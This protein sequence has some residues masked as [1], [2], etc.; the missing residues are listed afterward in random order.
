[1]DVLC[2]ILDCAVADDAGQPLR[3]QSQQ[4]ALLVYAQVNRM[5]C[6]AAQG[7][8]FRH[9]FLQIRPTLVSFLR[10]ITPQTSRG[11]LLS[12]FVRSVTVKLCRL[13]EASM[14]N[15]IGF[16]HPRHLSTL[17]AHLPSLHTLNIRMGEERVDESGL[18]GLEWSDVLP[19]DKMTSSRPFDQL[20]IPTEHNPW[21]HIQS[22]SLFYDYLLPTRILPMRFHTSFIL[23]RPF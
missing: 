19:Y 16:I 10:S 9:V 8:L 7:I 22:L 5:W 14:H 1:M 17:L 4:A 13:P 18:S 6:Q 20:F 11:R 3:Y 23:A 15:V 2:L 21:R 12:S